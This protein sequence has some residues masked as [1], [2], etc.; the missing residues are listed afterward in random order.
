[1]AQNKFKCPKCGGVIFSVTAH[2][3]QLWMVDEDGSFMESIDNCTDVIHRPGNEDV[4]ECLGCCYRD[5]G[6]AF[7]VKPPSKTVPCMRCLR[8]L[9]GCR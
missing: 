5:A 6:N 3:A 8:F 1:M 2:V 9:R 4:W 7:L